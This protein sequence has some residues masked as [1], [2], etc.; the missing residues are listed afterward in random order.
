[1]LRYFQMEGGGALEDRLEDIVELKESKS[2]GGKVFEV[3]HSG[4]KT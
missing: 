3:P 1:M 2:N 4:S